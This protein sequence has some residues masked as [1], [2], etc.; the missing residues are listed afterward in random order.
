MF[1]ISKPELVG[2]SNGG[3]RALEAGLGA[4]KEYSPLT[5]LGRHP[6]ELRPHL[7]RGTYVEAAVRVRFRYLW[8]ENPPL[9]GPVAFLG[10]GVGEVSPGPSRYPNTA[11]V[12]VAGCSV[13]WV[14]PVP[15]RRV[16]DPPG[17]LWQHLETSLSRLEMTM[18]LA[19]SEKRPGMLVNISQCATQN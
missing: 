8:A 12:R 6:D 7:G 10:Q 18:F 17:D 16:T 3:V 4:D 5:P 15:L 11:T 14:S 13:G 9:G 19:S 2:A 1:R